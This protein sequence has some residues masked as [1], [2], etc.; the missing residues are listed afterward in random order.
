MSD[1]PKNSQHTKASKSARDNPPTVCLT[2]GAKSIAP[3]KFRTTERNIGWINI[4]SFA[5]IK[6]AV[7]NGLL[8]PTECPGNPFIST[9]SDFG[10]RRRFRQ[11]SFSS[12]V[13]E[14]DFEVRH[15]PDSRALKF[16]GV[17]YDFDGGFSAE[18]T[19]CIIFYFVPGL[20]KE[21]RYTLPVL[22]FSF[23]RGKV[24]RIIWVR[25]HESYGIWF[26][27]VTGWLQWYEREN[28]IINICS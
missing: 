8:S 2:K 9:V 20:L 14:S 4:W 22:S 1:K 25:L 11:K 23:F 18:P 7:F 15:V 6:R 27:I 28:I 12:E 16:S 17:L 3:L 26:Y 13:P 24:S 19:I 5:N 10:F 21:F